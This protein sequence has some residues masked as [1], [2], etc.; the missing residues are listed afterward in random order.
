MSLTYETASEP[1]HISLTWEIQDPPRSHT[2][3]TPAV[4]ILDL[5]AGPQDKPA[6]AVSQK[7]R[8]LRQREPAA[9]EGQFHATLNP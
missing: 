4:R 8:S 3:S 7:R 5:L 6:T 9:L 1:L 2:A